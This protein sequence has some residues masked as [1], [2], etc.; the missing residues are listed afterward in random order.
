MSVRPHPTAPHTRVITLDRPDARNAYSDAMIDSLC[1]ALDAAED[2]DDVRVV[3][4]T[5]AGR[6]FSAGGDLKAMRDHE[7]MFGGDSVRL[8]TAY[9]RHIQRVPRRLMAFDKPIVAAINGP[10]IGAGLDL[11]CMCDLR[12]AASTA[13]F[14][15][16]FV[17]LGLVPGDGGAAFLARVVGLPH[18]TR[19]A[20]TGDVIDAQEALAL[21]LVHEV[22][23]PAS[24]LD[25]AGAFATRIARNAPVAVRLTKQALLRSWDLPIEAALELAATYQGIAQRTEDA[26]AGVDALLHRSTPEFRGR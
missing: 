22:V 12:V 19:L 8:R 10:A 11:A 14:G 15:S 1:A 25:A 23:D 18:A 5:G 13:R 20:L 24:L 3:V 9:A 4:L 17:T 21:G 16:T 6:A 2:D 26:D 7:G